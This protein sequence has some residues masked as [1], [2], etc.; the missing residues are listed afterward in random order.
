M[1]SRFSSRS[2]N[3]TRSFL[4]DRLRDAVTYDRISG[5]FRSTL[6]SLIEEELTRLDRVRLVC[7]A[8]IDPRDLTVAGAAADRAQLEAFTADRDAAGPLLDRVRWRR[9]HELLRSGKVEVRVISRE[10]APFLHGKAGLI[11]RSD[12]S[13]SAFIGS[14]NDTYTAWNL[15]YE[16]IWEDTSR[17]AADWVRGEFD[18]LWTKG[19]PL[20]DLVIEEVG[21][22]AAKFEVRI[23]DLR[24]RPV[25]L[26][27]A[28]LV[29]SPARLRGE[30]LMP[31]QKAFVS[32]W[33]E[34]RERH[35]AARLILADEVGVGKTLSM[36]STGALS[37]LMGDGPFLILCPAT[38]SE[39]WQV[40]LWDR[41][42]LPSAR[43]ARDPFK[44]WVD[45]TGHHYRARD[46]SDILNCPCQV[47]IVSTGLVTARRNDT[48][49]PEAAALLEGRFGMIALDEGHRARIRRDQKGE[50]SDPNNLWS[51]MS[52]IADRTRHLVIGTATPIQTHREEI[53]DLMRLIGTGHE[54]VLGRMGASRW[55][56]AKGALDLISGE[57]AITSSEEAWAWLRT[58]L[59][60]A[61]ESAI[62]RDLRRDLRLSPSDPFSA[63]PLT[64]L[65]PDT[66]A[67]LDR[68]V[69]KGE[70]GSN[71]PFLGQHNPLGRHVVLR[72]RR[73]LEEAGLMDRVA[74]DLWPQ[75]GDAPALFAAGA[76]IT[77][78]YYDLA[79]EAVEAFT[80]VMAQR[81]KA[82]G[83]MKTMLLQRICSSVASGLA[84]A[85]RMIETRQER[86]LDA[87]EGADEELTA[88]LE[89][90]EEE[91]EMHV[92][93]AE[94]ARLREVVDLLET[95]RLED[96]KGRAVLHFL[97]D[98]GWLELGC[99]IFSQ[100]YDTA[101]WTAGLISAAY[102]EEPVGLY[103][104]L[105]RSGLMLNGE[106]RSAER[107]ELKRL[108]REGRLRVLTA[109]DA[110]GEGLNLQTL[111]T[112]INVDLPW[113]PSRLEQRIGRIKRFGQKRSSV[114]M[115]SLVYAGT[116]D[117]RIYQR[118]SERMKDRYDVL[119]SL[120]DVIEG[121]WVLSERELEAR[122]RTFT[123]PPSPDDLFE[124]RYGRF[125]D[126]VD[127]D[128]ESFDRVISRPELLEVMRRPWR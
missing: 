84:S 123:T 92:L 73:T 33:A 44:G 50:P 51:F 78:H 88:L 91:G 76:V 14:V 37:V 124:L 18:W 118:L 47:G 62:F 13:T 25:D 90:L 38:L 71:V 32:I 72:R 22:E 113:N 126:S 39:Q 19:V 87:N 61:G 10:S 89:E 80:Q 96:P 122:L 109:T 63:D 114:D 128:W 1:I 24:A 69:R 26:M 9:L 75:P 65:D 5:Y 57:H 104:G 67:E 98:R 54:H 45:H 60:H 100:Y 121:A 43:W 29:E 21:R 74:V 48:L 55:H 64:D 59:P 8:E 108:V 17:E 66:R 99:I 35:G 7:N 34:H 28:A 95:E 94:I 12:G 111:G 6:F 68:L 31:W 49:L 93:D 107:E 86:I 3:L 30:A 40:E 106:W 77:P 23:R 117:E 116:V 79:Y 36:A 81:V 41:L 27:K 105:G 46:P 20:S 58:P 110:A 52:R 101:R 11:T 119:G 127:R 103:A 53:W 56:D 82:V 2:A 102:P 120:P 112:L 97:R 125:L 42:G 83:F 85:R 16:L 115:A 15:N 70:M 4:K